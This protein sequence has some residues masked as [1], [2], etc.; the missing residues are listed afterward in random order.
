MRRIVGGGHGRLGS[1]PSH[2][3]LGIA[4]VGGNHRPRGIKG[5][6]LRSTDKRLPANTNL[7]MVGGPGIVGSLFCC[8]SGSRH[9]GLGG[10]FRAGG[11][12]A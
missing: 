4:A 11:A 12:I 5:I 1:V 2:P 9:G 10:I 6:V 8:C 7:Q 3:E